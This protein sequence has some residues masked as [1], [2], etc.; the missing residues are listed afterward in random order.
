MKRFIKNIFPAAALTLC[1]GL[2][3]CIGDLDVSP[4]DPNSNIQLN[5]ERLFNMCYANFG[6]EG[7]NGPGSSTVTAQDAGTTGL[8]RQYFNVNELTTDE[9]IC[10]WGDKGVATM[11]T[12][13]YDASNMFIALYYNRLYSGISVCNQYLKEASDVDAT[14]TAE[15]RFIRALHFYLAM[16]AFGNITLPL[17]ISKEI[18]AQRSRAEVY[19]WLENELK[20]IEPLLSD[21]K[22]KTSSDANYGR[23]DKAAVW[24][25][26]SRLYLNAEVYSGTAQW[27]KAAEYAKKVI[28]SPY[29]LYTKAS[30][31]YSAYR[32]LFMGDNGESGASVEAVFPILQ[33]GNKTAGYGCSTFLTASTHGGSMSSNGTNNNWE[34]NRVRKDLIQKFFPG[35]N[36][37]KGETKEILDAAKD[38]R[39]LF[40]GKG[41]TLDIATANDV[42]TFKKGFSTTK[43]V[44]L[45]S[46]GKAGTDTKFS[47]ADFFFFRSAEAYLTYAEA[48]A[49][50]NNGKATTEGV[51][52]LNQLRARANAQAMHG[53][54]LR[55]ILDERSRE[56]YF[57]GL[58]R[59]DLIRYGYFGGN[60]TYMWS[61]KGGVAEGRPFE[62]YRNI[63]PLPAT[64]LSVG[65]G[66]Q[67]N[68]KY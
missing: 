13:E 2:S 48:T 62:D 7:L 15:V 23:V 35:D 14:R 42:K 53:Y 16:D 4:I 19:A 52:Y 17:T 22:A 51:A 58:R 31:G 30:N 8:V 3:S 63:F 6:I 29:K 10:A 1:V 50:Q 12:N 27:A 55:E 44:A 24:M 9:A 36:A 11:N 5:P 37:P 59:T 38:D 47:D 65:G 43:F 39:A 18:P 46:D 60:N 66:M 68:P 34:G 67:Q 54:T 41:R 57:E 20:E 26:L 32:K 64:E 25:L 45:H 40:W 56:F 28:D 61:W 49:R 33:Q 21:A